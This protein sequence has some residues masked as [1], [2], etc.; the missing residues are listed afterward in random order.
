MYITTTVHL[1]LLLCMI[2][3]CHASNAKATVLCFSSVSATHELLLPATVLRPSS[4]R[5]LQPSASELLISPKQT[6]PIPVNLQQSSYLLHLHAHSTIL[7]KHFM[8]NFWKPRLNFRFILKVGHF[9]FRVGFVV[10][11][12]CC[13]THRWAWSLYSGSFTTLWSW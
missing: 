9:R 2:L 4:C 11:H 13:S 5:V 6:L 8:I 12:C 7:F 10:T 1:I 3:V